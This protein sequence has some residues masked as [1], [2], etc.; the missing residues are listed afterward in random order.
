MYPASAFPSLPSDSFTPARP[1]RTLLT[2]NSGADIGDDV[3]M[4]AW[5]GGDAAAFEVLYARHRGALYRFLLRQTRNQS[6][7]DEFF[8]AARSHPQGQ[9]MGRR[10]ARRSRC[11]PQVAHCAIVSASMA[12]PCG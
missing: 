7:A 12:D 8:Q 4:L 6:L 11:G 10:A 2:M 1:A 3:L 5:T 9:G